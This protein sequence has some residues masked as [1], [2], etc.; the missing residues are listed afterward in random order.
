MLLYN[1]QQ[2]SGNT[3]KLKEKKNS[4]FIFVIK[5]QASTYK[6]KDQNVCRF[7]PTMNFS[8]KLVIN[9]PGWNRDRSLYEELLS[10]QT[11]DF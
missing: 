6:N 5:S 2:S 4:L 1:P 11:N 10:F 9:I 3:N 7:P 8:V